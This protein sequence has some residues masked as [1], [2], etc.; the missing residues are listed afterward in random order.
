MPAPRCAPFSIR[1]AI[2]HVR[3]LID[4]FKPVPIELRASIGIDERYEADVVLAAAYA[5]AVNELSFDQQRLGQSLHLSDF[6]RVLQQVEG[7]VFVDINHFH[8]KPPQ[9]GFCKHEEL[10]WEAGGVWEPKPVKRAG[11][12]AWMGLG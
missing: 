8:F 7:V 3:L 5:A 10:F 9:G 4:N 2:P 1:P 12:G 6:Y 11:E